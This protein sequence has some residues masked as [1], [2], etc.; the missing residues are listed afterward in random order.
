M[1]S[2]SA[3]LFSSDFHVVFD[4]GEHGWLYV[5]ALAADLVTTGDAP[6]TSL[7]ASFDV[8]QHLLV[9]IFVD[10]KY[11]RK[12]WSP[13]LPYYNLLSSLKYV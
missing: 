4:I 2:R 13:S 8:A 5:V 10:L 1:V 3:D 12:G 9:H 6:R 7:L 11:C